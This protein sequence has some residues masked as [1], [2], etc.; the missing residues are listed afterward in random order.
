MKTL[1]LAILLSLPVAADV[2]AP[3]APS[4]ASGR[5]GQHDFDPM[6]GRF[7]ITVKRLKTTL[8]G[9]HDWYEMTGISNCRAIWNGR[10]NIEEF[11]A[12]GPYGHLEAMMVRLYSP[13]SH[14]WSLNWVNQKNA[15]FDTP[16]V[17]EFKDGRGE[18]YDTEPI[19]GRQVLVRYVWSDVTAKTGHF[20]QSYS[21]DGGRT[22]EANWI[23]DST[24]IE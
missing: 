16:T 13:A 14:Q 11:E 2:P 3:V 8:R 23:A 7:K 4:A 6:I 9:A 17:G 18:F 1:L 15:R 10:A 24:R 5:D 19:D 22:W 21:A 12:D 20:E